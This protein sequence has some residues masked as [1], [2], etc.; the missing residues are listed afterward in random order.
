MIT[1]SEIK[2]GVIDVT[3]TTAPYGQAGAHWRRVLSGA[4]HGGYGK[5]YIQ[6]FG[7]NQRRYWSCYV[8]RDYYRGNPGAN[9]DECPGAMFI[10]VGK[11]EAHVEAL[12]A[13]DNQALG[14]ALGAALR[15]FPQNDERDLWEVV[16]RFR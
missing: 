2:P 8:L 14:R 6:R 1:T 15:K 4:N 12:D 10:W 11:K 5:I 7:A 9:L 3:V 13:I 16:F